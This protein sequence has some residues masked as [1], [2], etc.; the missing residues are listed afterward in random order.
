MHCILAFL[1]CN[2]TK[3]GPTWKKGFSNF[4]VGLV[5]F[6]SFVSYFTGAESNRSSLRLL[7]SLSLIRAENTLKYYSQIVGVS[8][9]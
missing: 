3:T 8:N 6:V 4:Q 9:Y 2:N 5:V 7:K 1:K